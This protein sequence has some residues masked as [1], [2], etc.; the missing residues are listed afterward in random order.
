[1]L[2]I[3]LLNLLAMV[4]AD[5]Y[6]WI[7]HKKM[8]KM[9]KNEDKCCTGQKSS[10]LVVQLVEENKEFFRGKFGQEAEADFGFIV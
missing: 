4:D 10:L 3:L 5:N 9:E 7:W 2:V 8:E 6:G 1:M